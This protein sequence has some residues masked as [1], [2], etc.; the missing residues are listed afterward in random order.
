MTTWTI[1][2]VTDACAMTTGELSQWISRG[3]FI[4]S[5]T[6]EN[7]N[8]RQFDWRDL[9]CLAVMSALRKHSLLIGELGFITSE[10]REDLDG[11]EEITASVGLYFFCAGWSDRQPSPTVGLVAEEELA[12][13][14]KHRPATIIVVDVA[15]A[16]REAVRSIAAQAD[17]K[18]PAS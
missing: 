12:A 5:S 15:K 3:H 10:L 6:P 7:G 8:A 16:Y 2:E 11:I 18:G 17:G 13:V 9:A 14:L 4:P 1:H